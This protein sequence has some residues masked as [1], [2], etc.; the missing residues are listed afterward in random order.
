MSSTGTQQNDPL[1]QLL[2]HQIALVDTVL[3][4]GGRRVV[5]LRG[6]VGLG[7]S[8]ALAALASR[9]LQDKPAA[10]ALLL[11]AGP[12]REQF[13]ETLRKA[14]TP[15]LLMDRYRFRERLDSTSEGE[16]WPR[17]T[18]T[19]LSPDFAKQPDILESLAETSWDLVIA[20]EAHGFRGARAEALRRVGASAE[21]VVLASATLPDVEH[22]IP[23]QGEDATV[24]EWRWDRLVDHDGRLLDSAPRPILHEVPF[25][26]TPPE[27]N[28]RETA[29]HLCNVLSENA[30]PESL[31]TKRIVRSLES[32]PPALESTLRGLADRPASSTGSMNSPEYVDEEAPEDR[33]EFPISADITGEAASI[34]GRALEQVDRISVDS[35]LNAFGELLS[36]LVGKPRRVCVLTEYL[37]TLFYLTAEIEGRGMNHVMLHGG[38][39]IEGRQHSLT[40]FTESEG[41][42]VATLAAMQGIELGAVTDL[43]LYD[44]PSSK[45][46]LQLVLSRFNRISRRSQMHLHVLTTADGTDDRASE[47]LQFLRDAL[48]SGW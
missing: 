33:S 28:L 20:D 34:V 17:G 9:L 10:R 29:R 48:D 41:F 3:D 5:L 37:A 8:A 15:S 45:I 43:V 4:S 1:A 11:V 31:I 12:V 7:K 13:R 6:D 47:P 23:F 40:S 16:I 38:M 14:G 21:R 46:R 32:S 19:I 36:R 2:P 27:L 39:S 44:I 24:V 30:D 18:V 22:P 42:L 26:L 35:K 25:T